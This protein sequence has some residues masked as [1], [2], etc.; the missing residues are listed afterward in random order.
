MLWQ[1]A[2]SPD[3]RSALSLCKSSRSWRR[4]CWRQT[5]LFFPESHPQSVFIK[6]Q[7]LLTRRP[8]SSLRWAARVRAPVELETCSCFSIVSSEH[9]NRTGQSTTITSI[10]TL[11][12]NNASQTVPWVFV[13]SSAR[14]CSSSA[15]SLLDSL[16]RRWEHRVG[17]G[18]TSGTVMA[19]DSF[20]FLLSSRAADKASI[21]RSRS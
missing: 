19:A 10:L 1:Q 16:V 17:L 18:S 12:Y 3:C 14:H 2:L 9:T 4:P 11:T 20:A 21:S 7:Y 8:S 15:R 6:M 13:S 5:T